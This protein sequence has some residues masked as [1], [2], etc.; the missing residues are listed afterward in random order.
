MTVGVAGQGGKILVDCQCGGEVDLMAP[1]APCPKCGAKVAM[2]TVTTGNGV[3]IKAGDG[4]NGGSIVI[5]G[6]V[7][8]PG[9]KP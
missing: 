1:D 5:K 3:E 4:P 6:G 9:W 8:G 7:I 2:P